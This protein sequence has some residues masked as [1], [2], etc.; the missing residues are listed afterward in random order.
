MS[1]TKECHSCGARSD[2]LLTTC[3]YCKTSLNPVPIEDYETEQIIES[4][5]EWI[6]KLAGASHEKGAI[7]GYSGLVKYYYIPYETISG[8]I[9]KYFGALEVRALKEPTLY[10][11]IPGL[12]ARYKMAL[13]QS[14]SHSKR[15]RNDDKITT[16][17]AF[18]LVAI[19][20]IG[21][22][23]YYLFK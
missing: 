1:A 6:G 22:V 21:I 3:P 9:N 17:G 12:Q 19:M 8:N 14:N 20:F 7:I 2:I 13:E 23:L 15:E 4:L 16:I 10:T 18:I 11:I 5:S